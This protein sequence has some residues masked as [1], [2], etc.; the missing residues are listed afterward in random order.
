MGAGASTSSVGV[1]I[2]SIHMNLDNMENTLM[3]LEQ[4]FSF[5]HMEAER[6]KILKRLFK[7]MEKAQ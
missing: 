4:S 3:E 7:I 2:E 6:E 5:K 1:H